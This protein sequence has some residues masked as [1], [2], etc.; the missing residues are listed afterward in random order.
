M[1]QVCQ[2]IS[3]VSFEALVVIIT[4]LTFFF[5]VCKTKVAWQFYPN[6]YFQGANCHH[7]NCGFLKPPY[8]FQGLILAAHEHWWNI[9]HRWILVFSL[10]KSEG[11]P[12][13]F[14]ESQVL[15]LQ[16]AAQIWRCASLFFT[17]YGVW[18]FWH[19]LK[20]W[21]LVFSVRITPAF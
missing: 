11:V 7:K 20:L 21:P 19:S 15:Q 18:H 4:F 12:L 1:M 5:A 2:L 3:D 14:P 10:H 8:R 13:F 6:Y 9:Y 16:I 17:S